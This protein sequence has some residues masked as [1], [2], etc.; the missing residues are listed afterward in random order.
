M[1]SLYIHI[2]FCLGKCNY[3]SFNSYAGMESLYP[4]YVKALK[5]EIV[6]LFFSGKTEELDTIFLG[7]GTPTVLSSLQLGD[8]LACCQEYLGISEFAEISL[9][10]NPKTVDFMKLLQ[11]RQLGINRLSIGLQS[12]L[13]PELQYLERLH[14]AQHGWDCVQDAM[15]AGFDNVS[16]DLM[17]GVP[18][19]TSSSWR[20]SLDTALSLE[21]T[22]LSLYQLTLE[23]GTPLFEIAEKQRIVFPEEDEILQMDLVTEELCNKAGM[24]Q[25][26]ISNY[27]QKG[28]E[29]RHNLNYWHN[30][31]Y[32]AVGA[33]AVSYHQGI[34]S[35]NM[36]DPLEYCSRVE[37]GA[38]VVI[39]SEKLS[40]EASF[41]ESVVV[42]LRMT[43]GVDY[44]A[45][46][47]RFGLHLKEY[48]GEIID[49]LI[50]QGLVEFYSI[51][52]RLTR[53]GRPVANR[54]MMELV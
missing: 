26:E 35:K 50:E 52:F 41:R 32:L 21:P 10:A 6:E 20:W 16:L 33:G 14:S 45:L 54:V 44:G 17:Y 4:R 40:K 27:A 22:H 8:I 25:Y 39:E 47:D 23:E 11:L 53:K 15:G 31:D 12:F 5:K 2:P 29:C 28:F 1:T 7:G 46:Y 13:D 36:A 42:G 30:R 18:G 48:Y 19:Q 51:Y 43:K 9:E 24:K 3:C 38:N 37:K 49:R 34:R